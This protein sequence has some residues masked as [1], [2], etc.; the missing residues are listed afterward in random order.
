MI[1][2]TAVHGQVRIVAVHIG[3][4]TVIVQHNI[5]SGDLINMCLLPFVISTTRRDSELPKRIWTHIFS[6]DNHLST[7]DTKSR[8][9]N[10][11]PSRTFGVKG[12]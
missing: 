11:F 2:F 8:E 5:H 7:L 10:K 12:A 3:I 1:A 9:D 6:K 4:V